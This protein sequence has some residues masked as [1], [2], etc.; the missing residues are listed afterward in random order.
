MDFGEAKFSLTKFLNK[1]LLIFESERQPGFVY[2][3]YHRAGNSYNCTSCKSLRKMRAIT[4]IDGRIL[5]KK[6]P[7]DDHHP[8]CKPTSTVSSTVT[9]IDREMRKE[10]RETGKRPRE[11]YTDALT[12]ISKRYKTSYEQ[13]EV[14]AEFPSFGSIRGALNKHNQHVKIPVPNP[15]NIPDELQT[16]IR[17][18]S[19][20]ADDRI[21]Q[22]SWSDF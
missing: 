19:V 14:I 21:I 13:Q 4:V 16:T 2:K 1:S 7:E 20:N 3:F 18:K 22:T 10:I 11:A 15:F 9:E 17:G 12:R 6:H 8:D 5:G